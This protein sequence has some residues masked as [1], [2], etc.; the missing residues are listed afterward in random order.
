MNTKGANGSLFLCTEAMEY[1]ETTEASGM[2]KN[3]WD[4]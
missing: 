2:K 3:V 4:Y 1:T